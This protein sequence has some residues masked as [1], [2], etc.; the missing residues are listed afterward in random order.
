MTIDVQVHRLAASTEDSRGG[1]PAGVVL[2]D[3]RL[4]DD[5]MQRLAADVGHSETAFLSHLAD[6]TF[7][8]RYFAP[9]AEVPFCGHATIASAVWLGTRLGA[10]TYT[11]STNTGPVPVAVQDDH[12]L[13]T[14]TLTSVPA[15]GTWCSSFAT[16]PSWPASP[17][18]STTR[19]PS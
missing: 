13:L 10:G 9:S 7:E 16:T 8:V 5:Q 15:H 14:A 4:S 17:T 1:N 12:G 18:T 11:F 3:T 19:R 2:S 6:R